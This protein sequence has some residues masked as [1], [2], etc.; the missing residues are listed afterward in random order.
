LPPVKKAVVK[1]IPAPVPSVILIPD[2]IVEDT[3]NV[4]KQ[5]MV[6]GDGLNEA[7]VNTEDP[8]KTFDKN[9]FNQA[10]SKGDPHSNRQFSS[11]PKNAIKP[12][13]KKPLW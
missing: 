9:V 3:A 11:K 4:N 13:G 6:P 12:S 2:G 8:V 1:K 7:P 10:T 5:M